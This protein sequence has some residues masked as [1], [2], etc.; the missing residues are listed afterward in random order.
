MTK[1]RRRPSYG[2]WGNQKS[3]NDTRAGGIILP[4]WAFRLGLTPGKIVHDARFPQPTPPVRKPKRTKAIGAATTVNTSGIATITGLSIPSSTAKR[5]P[6]G[7]Y[8]GG[9]EIVQ[10][11]LIGFKV[12]YLRQDGN[13]LWRFFPMNHGEP[14]GTKEEAA[15]HAFGKGGHQAPDED[16]TC[17]FYGCPPDESIPYGPSAT[18]N[19]FVDLFVQFY[20]KVVE[21]TNGY[22]AQFQKVTHARVW[23]GIVAGRCSVAQCSGTPLYVT[24]KSLKGFREKKFCNFHKHLAERELVELDTDAMISKLEADL[25][26]KWEFL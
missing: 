5:G 20:G 23:G 25:P 11:P 26:T 14:Y 2:Y 9:L 6:S 16:C 1:H 18:G 15:C 22:R 19:D 12:A 7:P 4:G 24:E 10:E 3:N 8:S 17:G 13:G 21:G